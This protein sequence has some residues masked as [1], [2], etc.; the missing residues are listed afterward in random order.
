MIEIFS[1]QTMKSNSV[2]IDDFSTNKVSTTI[3]LIQMLRRIKKSQ[4]FMMISM[5]WYDSV[6]E[7]SKV[8]H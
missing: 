1:W 8:N 4:I 2:E 3:N 6:I 7:S 5:A